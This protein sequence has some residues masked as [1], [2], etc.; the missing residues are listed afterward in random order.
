MIVLVLI[1][2]GDP[3]PT[4][5]DRAPGEAL[6]KTNETKTPSTSTEAGQNELSEEQ[7]KQVDGGL[8]GLLRQADGSVSQAVTGDGSV[9]KAII[10]V[11]IG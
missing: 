11:L 8:I 10:A 1:R 4:R 6:M 9:S 5:P 3:R 2:D 7:L